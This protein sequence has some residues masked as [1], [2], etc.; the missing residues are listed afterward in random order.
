[1]P[2]LK[3]ANYIYHAWD[4]NETISC[5]EGEQYTTIAVIFQALFLGVCSTIGIVGNFLTLYAIASKSNLQHTANIFVA[6]LA[7]ADFTVCLVLEPFYMIGVI[8]QDWPLSDELC[9]MLG[10]LNVLLKGASLFSLAFVAFNR[11]ICI[12]QPAAMKLNLYSSARTVALCAVIW[13]F[14]LAVS[15]PPI[16]GFG[17]YG[18]DSMAHNCKV[19]CDSFHYLIVLSV[20]LFTV[21]CIILFCYAG[22]FSHVWKSKRRVE[23]SAEGNISDETSSN[24]QGVCSSPERKLAR[25]NRKKEI[26]I[27]LNLFTIFIVFCICWIPYALLILIDSDRQANQGVWMAFTLFAYSNSSMNFILYSWRNKH[28]KSAYKKILTCCCSN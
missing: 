10:L 28:F 27:A 24:P 13:I 15:L 19:I 3:L 2:P 4:D 16:F 22:I 11:Y 17:S 8:K 1:M 5:N 12:T 26:E 14:P 6:N 23:Q 9:S 7:I 20:I 21:G 18:F 25:Q